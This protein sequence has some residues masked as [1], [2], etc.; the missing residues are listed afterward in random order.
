[1]YEILNNLMID[2]GVFEDVKDRF[3]DLGLVF[4]EV[5][6]LAKPLYIKSI[7]RIKYKFYVNFIILRRN[8]IIEII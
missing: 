6:D 7:R 4:D 8:S 2:F 1:M 3:E 5:A